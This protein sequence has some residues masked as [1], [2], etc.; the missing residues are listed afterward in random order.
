M[1][2][3]NKITLNEKGAK[4]SNSKKISILGAGRVGSSIAYSL[5]LKSVCSEIVLVDIA[6]NIAVGEAMDIMHGTAFTKTVDVYAG[7]Y[8]DTAGSDIVI[9]T[10]GKA[11]KEG[12]SRIELVQ[13]NVD[14]IKSVMPEVMKYAPDAIYIVVSNPVDILT[15]AIRKITGLPK[16]RVIG[17][18]TLLDSSRLR[19]IIATRENISPSNVHGY[20]LGEH[21][22]SSFIPWSIVTIAGM[23]IE[24]Y[25]NSFKDQ[26]DIIQDEVRNCGAEVIKNK[27]ATNHAIAM[28]VCY[29]VQCIL[30]NYKSVLT[31]S[32]ELNGEYGINN[33]SISI[34]AII[35]REGVIRKLE[36][37]LS[38]NEL[39]QLKN[40]ANILKEV[41]QSVEF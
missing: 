9:L 15:Y 22:D 17:T 8:K 5:V 34:P 4:M 21:G 27:G 1:I 25:D 2:A 24:D 40:S 7:D 33:V 39:S 19:S 29:L 37:E 18:G 11:R 13:S 30:S 12:Q 36:P 3:A 6:K 41:I 23:D 38:E 16:E 10:L 31:V 28:S 14:I 26:L 20:V 35:G 32:N